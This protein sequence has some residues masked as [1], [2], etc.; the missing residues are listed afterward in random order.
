MRRSATVSGTVESKSVAVHLS[1]EPPQGMPF[2]GRSS[3]DVDVAKV[4][5]SWSQVA[6]DDHSLTR[7]LA[8]ER[9]RSAY[10][11]LKDLTT[12]GPEVKSRLDTRLEADEWA[13]R[14]AE[15][16]ALR[17]EWDDVFY[18]FDAAVAT[19]SNAMVER[20]EHPPRKPR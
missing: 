9:A 4:P 1:W 3:M 11:R 8:Y 10:D 2:A 12:R 19:Y 14:V 15:L 13:E 6:P 17:R 16:L 5:Y 7:R 20:N 18:E